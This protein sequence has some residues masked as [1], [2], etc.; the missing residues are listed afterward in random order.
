MYAIF[1][2]FFK[3]SYDAEIIA[4]LV[5][6]R[7]AENNVVSLMGHISNG[8]YLPSYFLRIY[9]SNLLQDRLDLLYLGS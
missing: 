2:Y 5:Y 3:N 8:Q 7:D 9:D 1:K 6:T 4:T